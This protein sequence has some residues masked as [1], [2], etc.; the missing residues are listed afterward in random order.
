MKVIAW[1]PVKNSDS[2]EKYARQMALHIDASKPFML[3]GLSFGGIV[4]T[5][6]CRFLKPQLLILFSTVATKFEMR[7]VYRFAGKLRLYKFLPTVFM[8]PFLPLAYWFFGPL[9]QE[10]KL[11]IKDYVLKIDGSYL[12]WALGKISNWQNEEVFIPHIRIHGTDDRAFPLK[13]L[14]ADSFISGGGHI[15][16]FTHAE[17]ASEKLRYELEKFQNSLR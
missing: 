3:A 7:S 9:D 10:G 16:V 17:E 1:E 2:L 15:C 12:R 6:I 11:L 8:K 13:S 14:T 5:E 4:A